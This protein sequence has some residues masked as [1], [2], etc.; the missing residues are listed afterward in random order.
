[1]RISLKYL[2]RVFVLLKYLTISLLI[3][4]LVVWSS[5]N[6]PFVQK[7]ILKKVNRVFVENRLSAGLDR[8][9]LLL[10]GRLNLKNLYLL[11]D[12]DTVLYF[13]QVKVSV[14]VLPLLS[15]KLTARNI[16][17]DD[18]NVNLG[19]DP[20]T[21]ELNL[22]ALFRDSGK[23]RH[24]ASEGH[25]SPGIH[26]TGSPAPLEPFMVPPVA[27]AP[28]PVAPPMET[29]ATGAP[30]KESMLSG[31]V[32]P[33][34]NTAKDDTGWE[35]NVKR[36]SLNDVNFTYSDEESGLLTWYKAGKLNLSVGSLSI[37]GREVF[38]NNLRIADLTGGLNL[39]QA[40]GEPD[41]PGPDNNSSPGWKFILK[42]GDIDNVFFALGQPLMKQKIEF[43][44]GKGFL[45][46]V[47]F[48]SNI[49][50][51]SLERLSLENPRVLISNCPDH[52]ALKRDSVIEQTPAFPG[53]WVLSAGDIEVSEGRFN[54]ITCSDSLST[55]ETNPLL[56][57]A[58]FS[59]RFRNLSHNPEFSAF[60]LQKFSM[61][62]DNGFN[63]NKMEATLISEPV[64]NTRLQAKVRTDQSRLNLE[65]GSMNLL[66]EI[67]ASWKSA[68][69]SVLF[70][71]CVISASEI[72]SLVQGDNIS[73]PLDPKPDMNIG[74][75]CLVAGMPDNLVISKFN[76]RTSSGI[77]LDLSGRIRNITTPD[78]ASFSSLI[79]A[80]PVT[81]SGLEQI[82]NY[83]GADVRLPG[84][85][86]TSIEGEIKGT[87]S[88]I[89]FGLLMA[90]LSGDIRADGLIRIA[91]K[92]YDLSLDFRN[93]D[94][95]TIAGIK[96]A[97][98][99]SGKIAV[100]GIEYLPEKM[101]IKGS[102]LIDSLRYNGY[103]YGGI[104]AIITGNRGIFTYNLNSENRHLTLDLDGRVDY[105]SDAISGSL[106]GS[107][108]ID[109]GKLNLLKDLYTGGTIQTDFVKAPGFLSGTLS[110]TDLVAGNPGRREDIER[111]FVKFESSDQNVSG[112]L[113][114]DFLKAALVSNSNLERLMAL[115]G[116]TLKK[117]LSMID[118]SLISSIP[119][120]SDLPSLDFSLETTYDP[121]LGVF[122]NDSILRY[123]HLSASLKKDS[124]RNTLARINVDQFVSGRAEVYG[125]AVRF[126][127]EPDSS[128][129]ALDSDSIIFGG[130]SFYAAEIDLTASADTGFFRVR[131]RRD[132]DSL[133]YDLSVAAL[134]KNSN[135]ELS[136]AKPVWTLNGIS[137]EI[138]PEPFLTVHTG[139]GDLEADLHWGKG[140]HKIDLSGRL[141]GKLTLEMENIG[142]RML[143][144]P[145]MDTYGYD[146]IFSGSIGYSGKP[147]T[148]VDVSI[149]I[150]SARVLD[151]ELGNIGIRGSL[152]ADTIGNFRSEFTTEINDSSGLSL[153]LRSDKE[154]GETSLA[155]RLSDIPLA[156]F[157][158]LA[159][160]Y[161]KGIEGKVNGD[162]TATFRDS[163]SSIRGGVG[164]SGAELTI[165]P[166]NSRFYLPDDNIMI[167]ESRLFFNRF[168][169]RDSLGKELDLN[170]FIDFRDLT[171]IKSDLLVSSDNLQVM[172]TTP[173]ENPAF[174]GQVYVDSRISIGGP[175]LKPAISGKVTL[176]RGTRINYQMTD[177][178][179]ISETEKTIT[180]VSHDQDSVII[181]PGSNFFR[182]SPNIELS[183]EINPNTQ[184]SV[185]ISKGYDIEVNIKG[186]GFLNYSVLENGS[187]NLN[188][189]YQITDGGAMLKIPGWPR[190]DFSISQGSYVRFSGPVDDPELSI[191]AVSTVRGSYHNPVDGSS[192][193]VD[194][195]VNMSIAN[196]LSQLEI[197][198]DVSSEDPY[199]TTV[200][201][202][203]SNDERMKQAI[204]LVVFQRIELPNM[205]SSSDYVSQQITQFWESQ[206]NQITKSAFKGVDLSF[207]IDTYKGV[208]EQGG[209]QTYKSLTYV[210]KK[211]MFNERGSLI[212]SGRMNDNSQA[213]ASSNSMLDDF[214]FEYAL[215]SQR[216]KFL[217]VYREQNYEDILEGEVI[218]SGVGFIYRKTYN[219]LS[220]IW[221]KRSVKSTESKPDE[222]K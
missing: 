23:P 141:S 158:T 16:S 163:T 107:F 189:T 132:D 188:G 210:V 95:G 19:T 53:D 195:M 83:T 105:N 66:P 8:M 153:R 215:D 72:L 116:D 91:Q 164:F 218:K 67:L 65:I 169:I 51:I 136:S 98:K 198:F 54:L 155:T 59:A 93:V 102:L 125:T 33:D 159:D 128:F 112:T 143:A 13:R 144:I 117:G 206:L 63:I 185:G 97:E 34:T 173:S 12:G 4:F 120:I 167:E 152:F 32:T 114:S 90:G 130:L 86:T 74:L 76:V 39:A 148:E 88:D 138:R 179:N 27:D 5:V 36:I 106:G 85:D 92:E 80:G 101:R 178:L 119:Y 57:I 166:L 25:P 150:D 216:S 146:G 177:N 183:L 50:K 170:G 212:V 193:Q 44:V 61:T 11:D 30:G 75:E 184:F 126:I 129:L 197:K 113:E 204:N 48:D 200:L 9:T 111:L 203:L 124:L 207:G 7:A 118:S 108:Y 87:L 43:Q 137:W 199:V 31:T 168:R 187:M 15:R 219:R 180:F 135:I 171:G 217:K 60:S 196:R 81:P 175:L 29:S 64:K 79:S 202:S 221:K 186:G 47:L 28:D 194:F 133:M 208:S 14:R 1:M 37:S 58:S 172:N 18:A 156:M 205:T 2:A 78:I 140:R 103:D 40:V 22:A 149:Q 49:Q 62:L 52:T 192:R 68:N 211:N 26:S 99:V 71:D 41:S 165:I 201:G 131:T 191:E 100:E 213:G 222:A 157:E 70:E 42:K 123:N 161:L 89:E 176:D 110:I 190:K 142:L 73:L 121:F 55:V 174:N 84:F 38:V 35:I 127:G 96:E 151:N 3:L 182:G 134:R 209:E 104:S 160:N 147:D 46:D 24:P 77:N 45:E 154:S 181:E 6:L 145:G 115:G 162:I 10:D 69:Y 220:E 214:I 109:A 82:L 122:F 21:G 139:T 56:Q 17:V 94:I 20:V